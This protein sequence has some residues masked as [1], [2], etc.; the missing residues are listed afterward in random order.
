MAWNFG[1]R[2]SG[3][4]LMSVVLAAIS[5]GG[6]VGVADQYL[7]LLIVSFAANRGWV[8]LNPSDGRNTSGTKAAGSLLSQ[9]ARNEA[10]T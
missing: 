2:D 7:C 10:E 3:C 8:E 4:V 5:S 1:Y 9:I 6:L